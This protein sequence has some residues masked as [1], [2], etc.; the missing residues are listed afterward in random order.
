MDTDKPVFQIHSVQEILA[1]LANMQVSLSRHMRNK[2]STVPLMDFE[3]SELPGQLGTCLRMFHP[4]LP[5]HY[6]FTFV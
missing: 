1:P 4:D 6:P 5:E 3:E 2:L